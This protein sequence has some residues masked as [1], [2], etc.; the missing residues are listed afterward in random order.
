MK[1]LLFLAH[2]IPYPPDKGDKI[3]SFHELRHLAENG[4]RIH[5]CTLADDL[6]DLPYARQLK[7]YCATV[8]VEPID[9][10]RQRALSWRGLHRGLPLSV[11]Y[12]YSPKLQRRVDR[13]LARTA[14]RAV[15][16]FC[17]PMAEYVFRSKSRRLSERLDGW[18]AGRLID[19][20]PRSGPGSSLPSCPADKLVADPSHSVRLIMDLVDVDSDKWD[21]YARK[22]RWPLSWVY[23][24][25]AALLARYEKRIAKAF[26]ATFLV[27]DAEAQVFRRRT[28]EDATILGI[29][30][31]VDLEFFCP[32]PLRGEQKAPRLAFCGAMDYYPN[33]DAVVWFACEVLPLVRKTFPEA[34]FTVVGARPVAEVLALGALPG[35]KVTG[36]VDDVRP[37]VWQADVSVAPIRVARG[38]Q[39]KVLEAMAMGK[40]VVATPAA[41]EGIEAEPGAELVVSDSGP[42]AFGRAVCDL[43][44]DPGRRR[45]MGEAARTRVEEA[46][47]WPARLRALDV[48][49]GGARD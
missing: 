20:E 24:T 7:E 27:S 40:P 46:Y 41:F 5:L 22:K 37:Y 19:H 49:L 33:V 36:R 42:E 12:F 31:G 10:R 6:T 26:D 2:R 8:F 43:L 47:G 23:R 44:K 16:C 15:L 28:G 21:Q 25:E 1:D 29:A 48:L 4:W 39:N 30:N 34:E 17:S 13:I 32:K 14:V 35:V 18:A 11:P 3:R 9:S 45:G 38:I